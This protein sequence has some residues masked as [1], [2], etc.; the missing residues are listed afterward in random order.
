MSIVKLAL[1]HNVYR[2]TGLSKTKQK[3]GRTYAEPPCALPN[4][5][6][7][8]PRLVKTWIPSIQKPDLTKN[9]VMYSPLRISKGGEKSTC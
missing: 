4:M 7:L 8:L 3:K 1:D 9:P 5:G 2:V 6:D